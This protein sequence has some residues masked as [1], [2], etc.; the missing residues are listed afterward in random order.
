MY[1]L[2]ELLL[3]ESIEKIIRTEAF[4]NDVLKNASDEDTN[5]VK[6]YQNSIEAIKNQIVH[7]LEVMKLYHGK[8]IP[9]ELLKGC[10]N[11]CLN[12]F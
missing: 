8:D 10:I 5:I 11:E 3:T 12:V 4:L 1:A 9:K 7:P 6:L 2:R